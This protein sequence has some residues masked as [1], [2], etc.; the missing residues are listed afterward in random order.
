MNPKK[1]EN[2]QK[3]QKKKKHS[4][5]VHMNRLCDFVS[6]PVKAPSVVEVQLHLLVRR[7]CR[8]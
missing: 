7:T 8:E 6:E 1:C 3:T 2:L 5:R 4:V